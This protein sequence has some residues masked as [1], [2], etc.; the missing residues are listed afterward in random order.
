MNTKSKL[1]KHSVALSVFLHLL[2]GALLTA[3]FI[4]LA[5][6]LAEAGLPPIL[7]LIF[8][9]AFIVLPL[10]IGI[11]IYSGRQAGGKSISSAIRWKKK[12]DRSVFLKITGGL[13]IW[14][15]LM[16][17]LLAPLAEWLKNEYF[18]WIPSWFNPADEMYHFTN[19]P[20]SVAVFTWVQMLIVTSV[21]APIVEEYYFR[22][23]LLPAIE[24]FGFWAPV[25][26][27]VLFATYH[28]WSL[29]LVPVR[30]LA[31]FPV[32]YFVWITRSLYIAV[33]VHIL[34]NFIGDSILTFPLL[35]K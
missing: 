18:N 9:D 20:K 2:P 7:G 4:L 1:I 17:T 22:G 21:A 23:F 31:L 5:P 32:V 13:L 8:V 28:F 15:V 12:P 24:P 14:A 29:W 34:L 19:Y 27:T 30:V 10:M 26:N 3:G 16:F 25:M 11:I 6:V 35:F 33:T